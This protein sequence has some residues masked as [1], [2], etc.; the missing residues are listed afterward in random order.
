MLK[1]K[2]LVFYTRCFSVLYNFFINVSVFSLS[3]GSD[4]AQSNPCLC[5]L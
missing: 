2:W 4:T 1:N 5:K 3:V